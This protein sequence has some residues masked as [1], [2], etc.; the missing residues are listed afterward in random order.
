MKKGGSDFKFVFVQRFI[1]DGADERIMPPWTLEELEAAMPL[2]PNVSRA[3]MHELFH[4]WGG[5]VRW[6]LARANSHVNEG[7]LARAIYSIDLHG[8]ILAA[9]LSDATTGVSLQ[10]SF[11]CIKHHNWNQCWHHSP[12]RLHAHQ[13]WSFSVSSGH[14]G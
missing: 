9:T 13:S 4:M 5:S 12:F 14:N 1:K 10:S 3:R 8:L 7:Y 2:F 6:L 11:L